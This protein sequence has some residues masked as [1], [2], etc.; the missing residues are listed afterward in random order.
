MR[1]ALTAL[2]STVVALSGLV[3]PAAAEHGVRLP[4][5]HSLRGPVTDENFYFVMTDRF[6]T[7]DKAND[8]GGL[9]DDPPVSAFDTTRKGVY[10]DGDLT[11]M[12]ARLDYIGGLG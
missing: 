4:G 1:R 7:G 2:L 12:R 10:D 9:G 8:R 3:T 11:G 5:L 6:E